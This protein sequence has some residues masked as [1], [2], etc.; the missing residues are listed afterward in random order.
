MFVRTW[1]ELKQTL[2]DKASMTGLSP[3]I[4]AMTKETV[5]LASNDAAPTV[6]VDTDWHVFL[7]FIQLG[8]QGR[9]NRKEPGCVVVGLTALRKILA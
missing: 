4:V 9:I 2:V 8:E 5:L 7:D 1:L 3:W 6:G